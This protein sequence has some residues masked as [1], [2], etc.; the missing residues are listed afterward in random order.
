MVNWLTNMTAANGSMN[1]RGRIIFP[2]GCVVADVVTPAITRGRQKRG[3]R[4]QTFFVEDE[5]PVR[6]G[7]SREEHLAVLQRHCIR[8]QPKA[9]ISAVRGGPRLARQRSRV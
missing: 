3:A 1:L 2:H 7:R 9:H 6:R 4:M 8:G 5:K